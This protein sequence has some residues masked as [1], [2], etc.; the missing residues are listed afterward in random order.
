MVASGGLLAAT[1]NVVRA[2]WAGWLGH[3]N[4]HTGAWRCEWG[5]QRRS[6]RRG[7]A[8]G[9]AGNG[10]QPAA[11]L[12]R[13]FLRH[14]WQFLWHGWRARA[15]GPRRLRQILWLCLFWIRTQ[16]AFLWTPRRAQPECRRAVSPLRAH[17]LHCCASLRGQRCSTG[18]GEHGHSRTGGT[19]PGVENVTYARRRT[20]SCL[21]YTSDAADE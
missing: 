10:K 4:R 12:L 7:R 19:V 2:N 14:I 18:P 16:C 15:Y 13:L 8:R 5:R 17:F 3:W 21:L 20:P 1:Y 6:R 11:A 9:A